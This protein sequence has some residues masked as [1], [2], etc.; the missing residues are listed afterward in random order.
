MTGP[1]L[2]ER[3]ASVTRYHSIELAPGFVTPGIDS[4]DRLDLLKLPTDLRGRT[5]HAGAR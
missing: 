4:G 5:V 3:A 1:S 2:R